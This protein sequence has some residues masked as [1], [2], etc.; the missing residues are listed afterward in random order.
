MTGTQDQALSAETKSKLDTAVLLIDAAE[1]G[2]RL[3]I[4]K[5][6]LHKLVAVGA[7]P[8]PVRLGSRA[9]WRV[10]ELQE[11]VR[12]GCPPIE[13]WER[14]RSLRLKAPVPQPSKISSKG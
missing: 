13:R 1:V 7:T 12:D 14:R 5:S 10:E 8:K 6:T 2:R 9:L 11:W 4:S 3:S